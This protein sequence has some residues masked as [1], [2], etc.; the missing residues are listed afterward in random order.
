MKIAIAHHWDEKNQSLGGVTSWLIP[1]AQFIQSQG[2]EVILL[3]LSNDLEAGLFEEL[4]LNYRM[5]NH[6]WFRTQAIWFAREVDRFGADI[7]IANCIPS[8]YR[9]VSHLKKH[10]IKTVGILH[11]DDKFYS[12]ILNHFWLGPQKQQVDALVCV[13]KYLETVAKEGAPLASDRVR[14][15]PCG[16]SISPDIAKWKTPL[17]LLYLG[18]FTVEQK[19]IL[20]TCRAVC[21]TVKEIDGVEAVFYGSGPE[22]GAMEKIK[23]EYKVGD[24]VIIGKLLSP[25]QVAEI[26][27]Q[28]HVIVLLSDYEGLP[29]ALEEGMSA[30]LVP[31][32]TSMRSG[33][34]ELVL[35]QKTGLVCKD[36]DIDFIACVRRLREDSEFWERLSL[37]ARAH[38][39]ENYERVA[40][41]EKWLALL[42]SLIT[43]RKPLHSA[44]FFIPI[45]EPSCM[46]YENGLPQALRIYAG[47]LRAKFF[48]K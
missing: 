19:Q 32:V 30:G 25:A 35:H 22:R 26:I 12:E 45:G 27:A 37:S 2:D 44:R 23:E 43:K 6:H 31:V 38:V 48:R 41:C 9:A 24:R 29:V 15:I 33:C 40:N 34:S 3:L 42:K 21:Q 8:A 36:R 39:I 13:S 10:S 28:F 16:V 5:C 14:C 47:A 4:G 46:T 7:F 17:R 11:S 18:R 20:A 1:F